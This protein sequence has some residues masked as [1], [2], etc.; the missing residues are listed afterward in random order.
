MT[1]RITLSLAL[2]CHLLAGCRTPQ[3]HCRV[4]VANA[5]DAAL[6]SVLVRDEAGTT[7]VFAGLKPQ[8][9]GP[10]MRASADMVGTVTVEFTTE[11]GVAVTNIVH[12]SSPVR[13]TF[14]GRVLFEIVA[15]NR[16]R[17]FILPTPDTSSDR[18]LPWAIPPAWQ[19][20]PTIPGLNR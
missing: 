18:D 12:L 2:A 20:A 6:S 17:V 11:G 10:Y 16:I 15:K 5:S 9:V 13:R 19:S 4:S 7:Y 8:G 14:D 3:G 1:T